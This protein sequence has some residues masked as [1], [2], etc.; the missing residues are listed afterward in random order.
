MKSNLRQRFT[1]AQSMA[2]GHRLRRHGS[3]GGRPGL[4]LDGTV[5][6]QAL[7]RVQRTNAQVV[8]DEAVWLARDLP[9][10]SKS[11]YLRAVSL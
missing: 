3:S 2:G 8:K 11:F 10:R 1:L 6:H 9:G 5:C 7:S 4:D